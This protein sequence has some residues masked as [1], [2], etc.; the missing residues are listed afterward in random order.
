MLIWKAPSW[1]CTT[2]SFAQYPIVVP[3]MK[4]MVSIG[5]T[6]T[7][8]F[9]N[10]SEKKSVSE[11]EVNDDGSVVATI[12]S[13]T[14]DNEIECQLF[15]CSKQGNAP[16]PIMSGRAYGFPEI[17]KTKYKIVVSII[18]I[19]DFAF[20][21]T[22]ND[23]EEDVIIYY[24]ISNCYLLRY[25][26]DNGTLEP[27]Q[28]HIRFPCESEDY[29]CN[30]STIAKIWY[31]ICTI[32]DTLWKI[33]NTESERQVTAV[34]VPLNVDETL[35][36]YILYRCD[37]EVK[38]VLL[39]TSGKLRS[40]T[41]KGMKRYTRRA[42]RNL[43]LLRFDNDVYFGLLRKII[44]ESCTI[45]IRRR[46]PKVD[47]MDKLQYNNTIN[48]ILGKEWQ[49]TEER[50]Y[51]QYINHESIDF[52]VDEYDTFMVVR[53]DSFNYNSR[54]ITNE[55]KNVTE[56]IYCTRIISAI[57]QIKRS[58]QPRPK[59]VRVGQLLNREEGEVLVVTFTNG[60]YALL[61]YLEP[62]D[63]EGTQIEERDLG[64]LYEQIR[65]YNM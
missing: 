9:T 20:V 7:L 46:K 44:G 1:E 63:K 62:I 28:N 12:L 4:L 21:F 5:S 53:Y 41:S 51:K 59:T 45:G 19:V 64:L 15:Q 54:G 60:E 58:V 49:Q 14:S 37:G 29:Y 23:V 16:D 27:I 61:K 8:K 56:N 24:G 10:D 18:N 33:M 42:K 3:H 26:T 52:L 11:Y 50:T 40:L 35:L 13:Y 2:P 57:H 48:L 34:R 22:M 32:Q 39:K 38:K 31:G 30:R 55:N 25:Q 17:V 43:H 47:T 65:A 6:V 36:D